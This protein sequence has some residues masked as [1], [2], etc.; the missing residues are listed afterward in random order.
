MC[1][2]NY[3]ILQS[4]CCRNRSSRGGPHYHGRLCS[5][6]K[7]NLCLFVHKSLLLYKINST[8]I[9]AKMFEEK[10]NFSPIIVNQDK[11]GG[12]KVRFPI[13]IVAWAAMAKE[14]EAPVVTQFSSYKCGPISQFSLEQSLN[15]QHNNP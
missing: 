1:L 11:K 14:G 15:T 13:Q 8:T 5:Y 10:R 3:V 6:S 2:P 9:I 7:A 12:L 4:S